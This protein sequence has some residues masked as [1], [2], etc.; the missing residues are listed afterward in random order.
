MSLFTKVWHDPVWSKVISV[1]IVGVA[2]SVGAYFL[3]W[4]PAIFNTLAASLTFLG[5][6]SLVSN[7]VLGIFIA[8]ALFVVFVI[9]AAVLALISPEKPRWREYTTDHFFGLQ[10]VWAHASDGSGLLNLH[11]LCPLCKYEVAP[12]ARGPGHFGSV[13]GL[14]FRCDSCGHVVDIAEDPEVLNNKVIRLIHQKLRTGAWVASV[15]KTAAET[16]QQ[17]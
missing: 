12:Q 1:A 2:A 8:C 17:G 4:W 7:W 6:T 11:C 3:N 15:A 13:A 10:W 5:S 16:P 14:R 9:G